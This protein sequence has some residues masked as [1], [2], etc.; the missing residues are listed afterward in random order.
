MRNPIHNSIVSPL[1]DDV[2]VANKLVAINRER[3]MAFRAYP[4]VDHYSANVLLFVFLGQEGLEWAPVA[5]I[6]EE[7]SIRAKT[8]PRYLNHLVSIGV[9]EVESDE[10]NE[11]VRARLSTEGRIVMSRYLLAVKATLSP[12]AGGR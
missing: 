1:F 10:S 12:R 11:I 3:R 6:P 8:L 7:T 9:L 5:E 4:T 2:S